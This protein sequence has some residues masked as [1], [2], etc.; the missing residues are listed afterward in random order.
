MLLPSETETNCMLVHVFN[1]HG[2]YPILLKNEQL[3]VQ[4]IIQPPYSTNFF[5]FVNKACGKLMNVTTAKVEVLYNCM[6]V[7]T[8]E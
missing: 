7:Q 3:M 8:W 4:L 1:L 5:S 6:L 2:G